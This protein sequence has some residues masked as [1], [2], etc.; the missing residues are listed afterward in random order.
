MKFLDRRN[1]ANKRLFI[2][3]FFLIALILS[4]GIYKY[5]EYSTKLIIEDKGN[6]IRVIAELKI[7]QLVQ[8][9]KERSAD[10]IVIAQ[11]PFFGSGVN[12]WLDDRNNLELK[13]DI[14]TRLTSPQI[15]FGYEAIYLTSSE[16]EI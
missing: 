10:A 3:L 13:R 6:K 8:W 12:E 4:F 5:Y 2:F 1:F 9:R 11:S 16:G 15:E 14:E 7:K